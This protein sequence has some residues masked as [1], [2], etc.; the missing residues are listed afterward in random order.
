MVEKIISEITPSKSFGSFEE[1]KKFITNPDLEKQKFILTWTFL[2]EKY[3]G[4]NCH[5]NENLQKIIVDYENELGESGT[6]V[7]DQNT[8]AANFS[9]TQIDEPE[10]KQRTTSSY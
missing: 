2:R 4:V 7:L 1:L 6:F 8:L 9:Y 10:I 5:Y 3:R